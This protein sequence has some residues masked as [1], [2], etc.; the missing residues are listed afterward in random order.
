MEFLWN[1]NLVHQIYKE[2]FWNKKWYPTAPSEYAELTNLEIYMEFIDEKLLFELI[3]SLFL[4]LL[5]WKF[6]Q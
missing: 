2:T 4:G 5:C 3:I 1:F 6:Y